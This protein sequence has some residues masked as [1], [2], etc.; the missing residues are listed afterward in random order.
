MAYD[1]ARK[2]RVLCGFHLRVASWYGT[3]A[4]LVL[5]WERAVRR[6]ASVVVA[7]H[8]DDPVSTVLTYTWVG[9]SAHGRAVRTSGRIDHL[10]DPVAWVN[11]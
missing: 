8:E 10:L 6:R 4:A 3:P 7:I 5:S 1:D 11:P 2:S 9:Q